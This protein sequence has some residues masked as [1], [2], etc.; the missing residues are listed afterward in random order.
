MGVRKTNAHEFTNDFGHDLATA[1]DHSASMFAFSDRFKKYATAAV[2]VTQL[3]GIAGNAAANFEQ[4]SFQYGHSAPA[5]VEQQEQQNLLIKENIYVKDGILILRNDGAPRNT[6]SGV[7]YG[8]QE[9]EILK[10]FSGLEDNEV[11]NFHSNMVDQ[12]NKDGELGQAGLL[13]ILEP[14]ENQPEYLRHGYTA[15]FNEVSKKLEGNKNPEDISIHRYAAIRF[16]DACV[17]SSNEHLYETNLRKVIENDKGEFLFHHNSKVMDGFTTNPDASSMVSLYLD[18]TPIS[19]GV[20]NKVDSIHHAIDEHE[21]NHCLFGPN[22]SD[23]LR[24]YYKANEKFDSEAHAASLIEQGKYSYAS[25]HA[26]WLKPDNW[27]MQDFNQMHKERIDEVYSDYHGIFETIAS[28]M[29]ESGEITPEHIKNLGLGD[30]AADHTYRSLVSLRSGSL[31]SMHDPAHDTLGHLERHKDDLNNPTLNWDAIEDGLVQNYEAELGNTIKEHL[32]MHM[33]EQNEPGWY[34]F[35]DSPPLSDPSYHED[36]YD[37]YRSLYTASNAMTLQDHFPSREE[38]KQIWNDRVDLVERFGGA[39]AT[40]QLIEH[41]RDFGDTKID[42]F[43]DAKVAL[44]KAN[45]LE[46]PDNK[47]TIVGYLIENDSSLK[48]ASDSEIEQAYERYSQELLGESWLSDSEE[49]ERDISMD[50]ANN[51]PGMER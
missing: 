16:G 5:A 29:K 17:Y 36:L 11:M 4:D 24:E 21:E 44:D 15:V 50:Q 27:T 47:Y 48:N 30:S 41:Y 20:E 40:E 22:S 32:T 33:I 14:Y 43:Y 31:M 25:V 38:A 2:L 9:S 10:F 18:S 13:E 7:T 26:E 42:R 45:Y 34:A 12:V 35:T 3:A 19:T 51:T 8:L 28:Q 1:Q 37:Y 39:G 49:V 23:F 46:D 6:A